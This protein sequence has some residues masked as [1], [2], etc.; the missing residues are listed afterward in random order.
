MVDDYEVETKVADA[1]WVAAATLQRERPQADFSV[2][3]VWERAQQLGF[4]RPGV[5]QHIRQHDVANKRPQP[6]SYRMLVETAPGRRRLFREGDPYDLR[7]KGKMVPSSEHLAA[8][9]QDLLPW[10]AEWAQRKPAM[11]DPL[12]ELWGTGREIWRAERADRYVE[13][14]RGGWE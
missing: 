2:Q 1:A 11:L 14:M 6:G 9:W 8:E 7:R 3:E 4:K 12:L 13:R 10:Y 5:L